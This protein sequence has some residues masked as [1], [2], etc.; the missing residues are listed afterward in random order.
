MRERNKTPLALMEQIVMVLVFALAAAVCLQAFVHANLLSKNGEQR[1][2]AIGYAQEVTEYCKAQEG[3]LDSVCQSL[4]GVRTSDGLKI[5]YPAENLTLHLVLKE[6]T[7][8]L[9]RAKILVLT[10]DET[11]YSQEIAWQIVSKK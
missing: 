11:I 7:D 6:K 5:D 8:Y 4:H 1:Q 3:D 2:I 9:Q 10:E